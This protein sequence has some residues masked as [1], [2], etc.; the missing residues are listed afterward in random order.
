MALPWDEANTEC[1]KD[2]AAAAATAAEKHPAAMNGPDATMSP[3]T[4][5]AN[6]L[7]R[8]TYVCKENDGWY[9]CKVKF[10]MRDSSEWIEARQCVPSSCI[11]E[12]KNLTKL[13]DD[14]SSYTCKRFTKTDAF[15]AHDSGPSNVM[16]KH[17]R[18]SGSSSTSG[19]WPFVLAVALVVHTT[20]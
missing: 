6:A 14:G 19:A 11:D 10:Q 12:T 17:P 9:W 15:I 1:H 16:D 3:E 5:K 2:R 18:K 20:K 7:E 8:A 13:A 4:L